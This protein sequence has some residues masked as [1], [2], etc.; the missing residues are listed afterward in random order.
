M[1]SL[2]KITCLSESTFRF[3]FRTGSETFL[4]GSVKY[5]PSGTECDELEGKY[6]CV[7]KRSS[8]TA[9]NSA[10]DG[11]YPTSTLTTNS[12]MWISES[13]ENSTYDGQEVSDNP[14]NEGTSH[15]TPTHWT[16]PQQTTSYPETSPLLL[17][18]IPTT[19]SPTL[20]PTTTEATIKPSSTS[21]K[22][23]KRTTTRKAFSKRKT[24]TQKYTHQNLQ[25]T[26][27]P[28]ESSSLV[29]PLLNGIEHTTR[30]KKKRKPTSTKHKRKK[31]PASSIVEDTSTHN[32]TTILSIRP[33]TVT[34]DITSRR[35]EKKKPT[36]NVSSSAK[37]RRKKKPK[38]T[39]KIFPY[40]FYTT[41]PTIL[42]NGITAPNNER[43]KITTATIAMQ[44]SPKPKRKKKPTNS[45]TN[46]TSTQLSS[47]SPFSNRTPIRQHLN[48]SST[49]MPLNNSTKKTPKKKKKKKPTIPSLPSVTS[50]STTQ[51]IVAQDFTTDKLQPI[52]D[53]EEE[54]QSQITSLPSVRISES[55]LTSLQLQPTPTSVASSREPEKASAT[56]VYIATG[57]IITPTQPL[58]VPSVLSTPASSSSGGLPTVAPFS[59]PYLW[60]RFL[61]NTLSTTQAVITNTPP[62]ACESAGKY[63]ANNCHEYYECLKVMW[64]YR[65]MIMKCKRGE[66]FDA[67][68]LKCVP[69]ESCV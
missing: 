34:V 58:E 13:I 33:N 55:P 42:S 15:Q 17:T 54:P 61:P 52:V 28:P 30:I 4:Y 6:A 63:P 47:P 35:S 20:P 14:Q 19:V 31:K 68:L 64:W 7:E 48:S 25:E 62:T 2:K 65:L 57:W 39:T 36:S 29:E 27:I 53:F 51:S 3:C 46:K 5:C 26:T 66:G 8:V 11:Q 23:R 49:M 37:P 38:T 1:C 69:D 41:K 40:S 60:T 12:F 22:K 45:S 18:E 10:A 9:L 44:S 32:P 16:E 56:E 21:T 24:S 43:M 67:T 59:C 50:P